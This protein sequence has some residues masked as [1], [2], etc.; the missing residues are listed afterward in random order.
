MMENLAA[1]EKQPLFALRVL[2]PILQDKKKAHDQNQNILQK[3][4]LKSMPFWPELRS[5][6]SHFLSLAVELSAL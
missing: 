5:D 1:N 4:I 3:I 6:E 2:T